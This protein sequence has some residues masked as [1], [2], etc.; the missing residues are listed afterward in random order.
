[1]WSV[2]VAVSAS[3]PVVSGQGASEPNV[4]SW[5]RLTVP[6]EI[7]TNRGA[8][9][10]DRSAQVFDWLPQDIVEEWGLQSFPASDPPANW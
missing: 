1:M 9:L 5:P 7:P 6:P 4:C 8:E 3:E 2:S 10:P